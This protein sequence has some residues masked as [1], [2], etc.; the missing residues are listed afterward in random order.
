MLTINERPTSKI[1]FGRYSSSRSIPT[2][3]Q[4]E[5][6]GGLNMIGNISQNLM[7]LGLSIDSG[8]FVY[9]NINKSKNFKGGDQGDYMKH[10]LLLVVESDGRSR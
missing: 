3:D 1:S 9:H 5:E 6:V 8:Y 7:V 10:N 4:W 2:P